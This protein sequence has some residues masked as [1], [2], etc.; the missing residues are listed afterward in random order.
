[1]RWTHEALLRQVD[2]LAETPASRLESE[3]LEFK[4]RPRDIKQLREWAIECAVAFAN[5]NGGCLVA[6][7]NDK[8]KGLDQAIEGVGDLDYSSLKREVYDATDPHILIDV[9]ELTHPKGNLLAIHVAQ[10]L[11]P[12][13]DGKGRAVIRVGA[14]NLPLKGSMIA[15]R[16][17]QSKAIDP[18][19][20]EIEGVGAEILD[21]DA[22]EEARR[23]LLMN[24]AH[25]PLAG[26]GIEELL[27][28]LELRRDYG[29]PMAAVLLLG[30]KAEIRRLV[31]QHEISVLHH[32]SA[33]HYGRRL[34][35]RGPIVLELR[36]IEQELTDAITL[37]TVQLE[38]FAQLELPSLGA[39]ASREAV[40]NA[41]AHRDY[42]QN[43]ATVIQIHSD[44]VVVQS[45][46]G[47]PEGISPENILRHAPARRN[48]L[49]AECLQ[50][51]NLANR[52]GV[53]VD[54]IYE[55][56][57]RKGARFPI[58]AADAASVSLTLPFANDDDFA[59]WVIEHERSRGRLQL[60][61][62][63]V[64]R[65]IVDIGVV[66]R[67][68]A[69]RQLQTDETSAAHQLAE[70][71]RRRLISA[72]GRGRGTSYV[73]PRALSERLRG[74]AVTDA[75]LRLDSEGVKLRIL[76][77]LRDRDTLRN[78]EIRDFS[79]YSRT[80]VLAIVKELEREGKIELRGR[81]RGAHI[82]LRS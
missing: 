60:D 71:R 9:E 17:A 73:L 41:I 62:L 54:R 26:T 65:Q 69:A 25:A 64:M 20:R 58:Y 59:A 33:A 36:R 10:G 12:H 70:M 2:L 66:D 48:S 23:L 4:G 79:G 74:R 45:P 39:E 68:S 82:A 57:L 34:D 7:V 14:S 24:P 30:R 63:I 15:A 32:S 13:T 72:R 75:D 18:S 46:G 6:G 40:V 5:Q 55:D 77:L 76:Q 16:M 11:P 67:W 3:T 22:V 44:Q 35:L 50:K 42:F 19:T 47:F 28:A 52:A 81:G 53:G 49:L 8:A 51:L 29:L 78:A 1:M 27:E 43:Q 31:P 80:Q 61:D 37:R 38:G 21:P 56:L